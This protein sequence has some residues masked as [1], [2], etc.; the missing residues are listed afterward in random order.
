MKTKRVFY[1]QI[2]DSVK[3]T[4]KTLQELAEQASKI[5]SDISSGNYTQACINESLMPKKRSIERKMDDIRY[6][7]TNDIRKMCDAYIEDLVKEDALNPDDFTADKDLL[8]S[9][10]ALKQ[11][12]IT[13]MLDRNA[14]NR[15]MTQ[16]ILRYCDAHKINT[17][18]HYIGNNELV[19]NVGV[20]PTVVETSLRWSDTSNVYDK[21][22]GENSALA[23][24]FYED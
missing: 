11:N 23:S 5:K 13:A 4:L 7:S 20:I 22:M 8:D 24:E 14:N 6:K 16:Y 21:L 9:G 15:T 12:D 1:C 19:N 18:R 10:I 17:G 2:Q 3:D